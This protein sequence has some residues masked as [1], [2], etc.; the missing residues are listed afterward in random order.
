[1]KTVLANDVHNS[2]KILKFLW[3]LVRVESNS[4]F[5][6]QQLWLRIMYAFAANTN[7]ATDMKFV[8]LWYTFLDKVEVTLKN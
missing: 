6:L 7:T 3:A 5:C 1:M 8:D 2:D 4:L